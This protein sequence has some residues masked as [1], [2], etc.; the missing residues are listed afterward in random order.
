MEGGSITLVSIGFFVY[1]VYAI[2][3]Y[4]TRLPAEET[5]LMLWTSMESP[6]DAI[7]AVPIFCGRIRCE[8]EWGCLVRQSFSGDT[9]LSQ[10]CGDA[11]GKSNEMVLSYKEEAEA[12][13]CYSDSPFDGIRTR[14]NVT[15][16]TTGAL[17]SGTQKVS[18]V[19][20]RVIYLT[21]LRR[22]TL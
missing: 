11:I 6:W 16:S 10:K 7:W 3:R 18:Y 21:T 12:N 15:N 14:C 2:A 13:F 1:F 22:T 20:R 4:Y 8:N 5:S 9:V 19:L 17:T